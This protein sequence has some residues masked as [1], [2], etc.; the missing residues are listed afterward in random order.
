MIAKRALGATGIEVGEIGLGAWQ[1]GNTDQWVGP[2]R[3]TSLRIVDEALRLGVNLFDTAPGYASGRSE[4]LLGEALD[5]RRNQAVIVSK[6]GHKADGTSDWDADSIA[7]A[8][9]RTLTALRTDYLDV[10]LMHSPPRDLLDGRKAR[11]YKE[12]ERLKAAGV[13]KAYGVASDP[14]PW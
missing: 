13:V 5:G 4:R 14:L 11:H 1:L 9:E 10:V 7:P 3:E 2:G 6:F 12:F 8:V